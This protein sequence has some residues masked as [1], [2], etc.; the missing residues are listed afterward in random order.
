MS[1]GTSN[2][3]I[4]TECQLFESCISLHETFK[5][6]PDIFFDLKKGHDGI[7]MLN[8]GQP[9]KYYLNNLKKL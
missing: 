1:Y 8:K 7:Q 9:G 4:I 2:V 5:L 6:D 3:S